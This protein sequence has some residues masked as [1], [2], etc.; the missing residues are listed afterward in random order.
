MKVA[1]SNR[2]H[3]GRIDGTDAEYATDRLIRLSDVLRIVPLSRSTWWAGIKTGRYPAPVRIG[4]RSVAWRASE[5][6]SLLEKGVK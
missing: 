2:S 3:P 5:I 4:A 1:H 6:A